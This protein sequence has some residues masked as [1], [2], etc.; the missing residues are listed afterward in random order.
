MNECKPQIT[1][2]CP[3]VYKVIGRDRNLIEA[4]AGEI[5]SGHA[6]RAVTS[7]SSKGGA[8]HCLDV[9]TIVENE[10]DRLNFY[11]RLR[12]H[13]AVVMVL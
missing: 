1:Y 11:N 8:Y 13:P 7:K 4:A 12:C 2:P 3:W 5:L 6:Y 10:A 9:E